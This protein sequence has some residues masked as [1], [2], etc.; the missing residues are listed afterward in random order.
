[1]AKKA[2]VKMKKVVADKSVEKAKSTKKASAPAAA[3]ADNMPKKIIKPPKPVYIPKKV[4]LIKTPT[5]LEKPKPLTA[6]EKSDFRTRLLRLRDELSGQVT[7]LKGE[8][9]KREDAIDLAE[10]GTDAFDRQFALNLAS[11]E[12]DSIFEIDEALR[13]LDNGTFGACEECTGAIGFTRLH[14]LPFVRAC[15]SCQSELEKTKPKFRAG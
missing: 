7:S 8:S 2:D 5:K 1:M 14:A 13:R 9:L 3:K 6:K 15:V 11:A 10:D 12:Q 4:S